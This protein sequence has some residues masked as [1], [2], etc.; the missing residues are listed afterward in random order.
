M[1]DVS[2]VD[3]IVNEVSDGL[4]YW[5]AP[6]AYGEPTLWC[7]F[8]RD[9]PDADAVATKHELDRLY[10]TL[11]PTL[12]ATLATSETPSPTQPEVVTICGSMRFRELMLR[13][14]EQETAAGHIVLMPFSVVPPA[15]QAGEFKAMLDQLHRRKIDLSDRVIVVHDETGY[16]GDSTRGEI[17][18]AT[19]HRKAVSFVTIDAGE[20]VR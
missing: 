13:V 14:A 15:E 7:A 5:V 20:V 3:A 10:P 12:V 2:D 17:E 6:D 8:V 18:Y 19:E 9:D 4:I 11:W 1:R 16:Y